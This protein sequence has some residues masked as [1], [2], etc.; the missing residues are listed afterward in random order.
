[1]PFKSAGWA[2]EEHEL[3]NTTFPR[4]SEEALLAAI[5]WACPDESN[6]KTAKINKNLTGNIGKS[7]RI[8]Q[9]INFDPHFH[10]SY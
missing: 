8:G 2:A 9:K 7:P 6:A 10:T 4:P 1:M 5:C 3:G